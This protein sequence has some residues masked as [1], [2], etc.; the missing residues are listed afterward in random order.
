M[1]YGQFRIAMSRY[2]LLKRISKEG[3]GLDENEFRK[4]HAPIAMS[5][6]PGSSS[7]VSRILQIPGLAITSRN[8]RVGNAFF[9]PVAVI[10]Q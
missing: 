6:E 4:T 7:P 8:T 5:G 1:D 10:P 2:T 3:V 9:I